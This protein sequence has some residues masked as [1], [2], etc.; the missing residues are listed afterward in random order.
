MWEK[1]IL[2]P[3]ALEWFVPLEIIKEFEIEVSLPITVLIHGDFFE[4]EVACY[5]LPYFC[6][7]VFYSYFQGLFTGI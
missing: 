4:F 3:S 2:H 5:L 7:K 6:N 1:S